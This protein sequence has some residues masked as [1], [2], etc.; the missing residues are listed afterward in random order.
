MITN[1]FDIVIEMRYQDII[2]NL[3]T[4]SKIKPY[5]KMYNNDTKLFI[6]SS[7]IPQIARYL[8]GSN[9]TKTIQFIKYILTQTFFHIE[10]LKKRSDSESV[11]LNKS[12]LNALK[13]S[14][15]GLE[16]LKITYKT[17]VNVC[18]QIDKNIK[19]MNNFFP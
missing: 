19:Y 1:I 18:E 5:D 4:I 10:L 6:E 16:N 3:H 12:I 15:K 7:Y 2:D 11:F 14:S 17:D 8:R 13:E 9:R